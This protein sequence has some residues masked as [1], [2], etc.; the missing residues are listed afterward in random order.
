MLAALEQ[1]LILQDRDRR[2]ATLKAELEALGPQRRLIQDR[3]DVHARS[4]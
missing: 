1:L 4:S 3:D 2:I